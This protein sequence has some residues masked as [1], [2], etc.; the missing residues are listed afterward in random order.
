MLGEVAALGEGEG[1]GGGPDDLLGDVV[2]ALARLPVVVAHDLGET[3]RVLLSYL[4]EAHTRVHTNTYG[5]KCGLR[6]K[7]TPFSQWF[8]LGSTF[9]GFKMSEISRLC[10]CPQI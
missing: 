10:Y 3:L 1:H 8:L 2:V 4:T 6:R 7:T 5:R 9:T